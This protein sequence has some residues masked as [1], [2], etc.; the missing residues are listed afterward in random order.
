M[1]T[2]WANP[3]EATPFTATLDAQHKNHV[4]HRL[5]PDSRV[6]QYFAQLDLIVLA[7]NE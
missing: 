4:A 3:I 7:P 6:A 2:P 5:L 1:D